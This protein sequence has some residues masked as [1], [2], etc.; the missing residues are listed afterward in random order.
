MWGKIASK[1]K[2]FSHQFLENYAGRVET[3][4]LSVVV[5]GQF[6]QLHFSSRVS[7]IV[8]RQFKL[9]PE[10]LENKPAPSY[11]TV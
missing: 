1:R 3:F 2:I 6:N 9:C 8:M 7:R 4:T 11:I 5:V 10:A